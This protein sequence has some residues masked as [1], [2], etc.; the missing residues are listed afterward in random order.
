ML[1]ILQKTNGEVELG[2]NGDLYQESGADVVMTS[3]GDIVRY[4]SERERYGIGATGTVLTVVG[5]LPAWAT[6][7]TADSVLTTQ[8]D[9]L[10]ESASGLARLGFGTTGDVLTTKGTSANPVWETPSAGGANISTQTIVPSAQ[11]TTSTSLVD[12]A[13]STITL[14]NRTDGKASWI[15]YISGRNTTTGENMQLG[16]YFNGADQEVVATTSLNGGT[17]GV[18]TIATTDD[19]DGGDILGRFAVS[20]ATGTITTAGTANS[21]VHVF[22]VS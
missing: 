6:L 20:S 19:L 12:I 5:G 2:F 10:Y 17:N 15:M 4:D 9:V 22:E 1:C 8:G 21:Q 16:V 14:A 18:Y 13:N 7:T 3:T 11:T